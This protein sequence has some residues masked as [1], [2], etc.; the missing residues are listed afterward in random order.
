MDPGSIIVECECR[1][2]DLSPPSPPCSDG[3]SSLPPP[4]P[5]PSHGDRF[6]LRLL[7]LASIVPLPHLPQPPPDL[8]QATTDLLFYL[9]VLL[10]QVIIVLLF[11][12]LLLAQ[13]FFA[14]LVRLALLFMV[15]NILPIRS[16]LRIPLLA[17]AVVAV[18]LSL[19]PQV[20]YPIPTKIALPN[21]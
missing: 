3:Q 2:C 15:V 7:S 11:R 5:T 13:E 8:A 4:P 1:P 21:L 18:A 16:S 10:A 20:L 12:I 19:H 9:P 17:L 6:P 14:L